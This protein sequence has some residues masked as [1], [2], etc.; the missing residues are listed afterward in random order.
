MPL[1][2]LLAAIGSAGDVNPVIG[3]GRA[4]R[5]R[6]HRVALA[7]N[8]IF[9]NRVQDNGLEFI[10][11]GT[12]AEAETVMNDPR[13]W[14][15]RRGF[16]C[17]VEHALLPNLKRL[18]A[19]V[20]ERRGP[21]CVVAAT[22]LCLGARVAQDAL[23]VPTATL[24]LQPSVIRS[25]IDNGR[26]G[27]I[28]MGP[29]MPR[30][31]KRALFW[32]M[33]TFYVERLIGPE[34]NRFRSRLCL[35][36]VKGIFSRYVHSPDLVLGLFPEW[37]APPQADWPANTHLT[38]F[39]LHD[40]GGEAPA[41]AEADLFLEGGPP[42]IVVTPGSAATDRHG[43]FRHAVKACERA[44]FRAMLVTNHP[45]QLPE[46]LPEGIRA[47]PYLPFSRILPR[48]RA[49]VYHGGI[50]TLAQALH[51]GIPHLIVPNAHDQPDNGRRIE[52]MGLGLCL[53]GRAF[54]AGAAGRAIA[55]LTGDRQIRERCRDYAR[56]IDGAAAAERSCILIERLGRDPQ[57]PMNPKGPLRP[58]KDR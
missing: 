45:A 10:E 57:G 47:F 28:T 20:S 33:D 12:R 8:E 26:L 41:Y 4:L 31:V 19:I 58:L 49:I 39:V 15:P 50:G 18:H 1:R 11:L 27:G 43:F 35:P 16:P 7:T 52:R 29:G 9:S 3:I 32:A 25:H 54:G 23:G 55:R 21:G 40:Q 17:I 36:P 5:A 14:H 34:L 6:G 51:A 48:C 22:T 44:G 38:G 2:I 24:H 13:L 56:R 53:S 37:F 30:L 46:R 42:P